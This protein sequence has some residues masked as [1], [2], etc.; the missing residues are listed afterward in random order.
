M[1]GLDATSRVT[2]QWMPV[3]SLHSGLANANA[4]LPK[5]ERCPF[6][7]ISTGKYAVADVSEALNGVFHGHRTLRMWMTAIGGTPDTILQ[8]L[9]VFCQRHGPQSDPPQFLTDSVADELEKRIGRLVGN[10]ALFFTLLWF[11]VRFCYT[12]WVRRS[13]CAYL[14][15]NPE[16]KKE[17]Q[18]LD[19]HLFAVIL[20]LGNHLKM[21]FCEEA[22]SLPHMFHKHCVNVMRGE[23]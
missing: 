18:S 8:L 21:M 16:W 23:L 20:C 14:Q 12:P 6:A 19:P 9:A 4:I 1:D 5:K 22:T 7:R 11:M 10:G 15:H 2:K 13:L 17:V 3:L